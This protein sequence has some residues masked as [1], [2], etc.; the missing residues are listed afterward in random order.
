MGFVNQCSVLIT[1]KFETP[2]PLI[3]LEDHLNTSNTQDEE[4]SDSNQPYLLLLPCP[5]CLHG[6]GRDLLCRHRRGLSHH[7]GTLHL[8]APLHHALH[9]P[10]ALPGPGQTV[11]TADACSPSSF[12]T[13]LIIIRAKQWY[14]SHFKRPYTEIYSSQAMFSLQ[15]PCW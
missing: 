4:I 2:F 14:C 13:L 12:Q 7:H 5:S 11:V 3:K 1:W 10:Q 15:F 8:R 6:R 9:Q